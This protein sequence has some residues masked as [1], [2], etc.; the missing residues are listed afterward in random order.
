MSRIN[1]ACG[2]ETGDRAS[3]SLP[4][5]RHVHMYTYALYKMNTKQN[6]KHLKVH[7]PCAVYKMPQS[8]S[9]GCSLQQGS[10][11]PVHTCTISTGQH[12]QTD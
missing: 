7:C 6:E 5:D 1:I 10:S 4:E 2:G 11:L 9:E 3:A 12:G 8:S